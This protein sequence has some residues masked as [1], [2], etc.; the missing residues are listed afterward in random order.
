MQNTEM[1][2]QSRHKE[3][4]TP[5]NLKYLHMYRE[6]DIREEDHMSLRKETT[7]R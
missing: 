3:S 2:N 5:D 1:W 7:S 6:R 4:Y